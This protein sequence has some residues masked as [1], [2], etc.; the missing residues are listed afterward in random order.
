ML[1]AVVRLVNEWLLSTVDVPAG[2]RRWASTSSRSRRP[3][4]GEHLVRREVAQVEVQPTQLAACHPTPPITAI[5]APPAW[6]RPGPRRR[7]ID[8]AL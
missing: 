8:G 5:F 1:G 7:A 3:V 4:Q 2:A 6:R